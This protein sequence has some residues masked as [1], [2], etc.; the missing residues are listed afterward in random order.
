LQFVVFD[1]A[2]FQQQL[3]WILDSSNIPAA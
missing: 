1:K 2:R 3:T